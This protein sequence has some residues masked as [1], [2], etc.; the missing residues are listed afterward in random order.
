MNL[1]HAIPCPNLSIIAFVIAHGANA[2]EITL[3]LAEV[4]RIAEGKSEQVAIAEAGVNR[5]R[6]EQI[7]ALSF[8]R[9]NTWQLALTFSQPVYAGGRISAQGVSPLQFAS[10]AVRPGAQIT[11]GER[12]H[13]DSGWLDLIACERPS[14]I[15]VGAEPRDKAHVWRVSN[16]GNPARARKSENLFWSTG[17]VSTACE[18]KVVWVIGEDPGTGG[19]ERAV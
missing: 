18:R 5:A 17:V 10:H 3:T 16:L 8:D 1:Q 6:G 4:V 7:R 12:T 15:R 19:S 11:S 14:R 2:Q 13:S 9:T